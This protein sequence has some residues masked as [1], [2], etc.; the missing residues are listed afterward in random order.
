[1]T[2]LVVAVIV[3]CA[4]A[5]VVATAEHFHF[6][7]DNVVSGALDAVFALVFTTLDTAFQVHL[8]AF[9]QVLTGDFGEF[10]VHGDVVPF[11]TFYALTV[12]VVP[13]FTG[14]NAEVTD[15]LAVGHIA[16]FWVTAEAADEDNF[17]Q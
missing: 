5:V 12:A 17:I 10:A 3:W 9:T 11:G 14:G 4:A 6:V 8:A 16:D 13:R 2:T 1:M 7:G 15:G